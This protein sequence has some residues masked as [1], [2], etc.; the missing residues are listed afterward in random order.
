MKKYWHQEL[1]HT[2]LKAYETHRRLECWRADMN[3][4]C[5]P[6]YFSSQSTDY[7]E[8]VRVCMGM[9]LLWRVDLLK[10]KH[11]LFG[12]WIFIRFW[13]LLNI[14]LTNWFVCT[15]SFPFLQIN[16]SVSTTDKCPNWQMSFNSK[17]CASVFG[18]NFCF[19]LLRF[20]Y[21]RYGADAQIC[22]AEGFLK[23]YKPR[24]T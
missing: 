20:C 11:L 17:S 24:F 8:M 19:P 5:F 4:H 14:P 23:I 21:L 2:I 18:A 13:L 9:D 3:C 1:F 15:F 7:A 6:T 16:I 12:L 10:R 22:S